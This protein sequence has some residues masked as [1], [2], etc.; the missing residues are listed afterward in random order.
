[1]AMV[2]SFLGFFY[3]FYLRH[4]H[5]VVI[6]LHG[7]SAVSSI[8]PY[9]ELDIEQHLFFLFIF[10]SL[11]AS[12]KWVDRLLIWTNPFC[13]FPFFRYSDSLSCIPDSRPSIFPKFF[14]DCNQLMLIIFST[15]PISDSLLFFLFVDCRAC[16]FLFLFL[17]F[18]FLLT[19]PP[20]SIRRRTN[21]FRRCGGQRTRYGSQWYQWFWGK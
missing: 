18:L 6:L 5:L 20:L 2:C 15:F 7:F 11:T 4:S 12:T 9:F 1:M 14:P 8:L 13:S 16:L 10:V 3:H 19:I 17:D 21:S